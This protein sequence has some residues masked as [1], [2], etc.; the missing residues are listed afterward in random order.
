MRGNRWRRSLGLSFLGI[1]LLAATGRTDCLGPLLSDTADPVGDNTF[2][3]QLLTYPF[4]KVG[5]FDD[6]GSLKY[7]PSGDRLVRWTTVLRPYY[8]LTEDW[9]VSADIPY[10]YHWATQTGR[11]AQTGGLGDLLLA[12]KYRFLNNDE[13]GWRP[14]LAALGRVKFPTGKYE[15]LADN[16]LEA[17][18]TGNGSYEYILGL[19]LSKP[20]GKW[21]LH[22]SVLYDYLAEA[23]LDGVS[24]R[25]GDIWSAQLALEFDFQKNASLVA[26]LTA[27]RQAATR[28]EGQTQEGTDG[29]LLTLVL[30]AAWRFHEKAVAMAGVMVTPAGKNAEFGYTPGLLISYTY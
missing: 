16:L 22:V 4:I 23:R 7:L 13:E 1:L 25:P 26:E 28:V 6:S 27:Y 19:A 11:S 8:G 2:I 9:E 30:A 18:R 3:A 17:D 5:D 10:Y 21:H 15:G 12:T 29:R 20:L 14:A 24:T